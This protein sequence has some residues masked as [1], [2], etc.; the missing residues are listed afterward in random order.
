MTR[1]LLFSYLLHIIFISYLT[2][3]DT[4]FT[5]EDRTAWLR[6]QRDDF[7]TESTYGSC[8]GACLPSQH[9]HC[10]LGFSGNPVAGDL[11]PVFFWLL[12]ALCMHMVHI[13]ACRQNIHMKFK[14][15]KSNKLLA[16][17]QQ[18]QARGERSWSC[19][20]LSR[21]EQDGECWWPKRNTPSQESCW[22]R[23]STLWHQ[24]LAY[25][26]L[27]HREGDFWWG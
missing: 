25:I 20:G 21:A 7:T 8:R 12:W 22:S 24:P 16:S 10:S 11:I 5:T 13:H 15:L 19:W 2:H 9:P 27:E 1:G 18:V 17:C 6:D 4:T 3:W 14:N 26:S 23:N